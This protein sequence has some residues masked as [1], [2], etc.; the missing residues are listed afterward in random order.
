MKINKLPQGIERVRARAWVVLSAL[1]A[2][3]A[4]RPSGPPPS[5]LLVTIDTL[6]ADRLGA[7]GARNVRTPVLDALAARGVLFEEALASA[8]LTLPS[9]ST[10]LSGLEPPRHG[11]R[12]NGTY[13]FPESRDTLATRL[14]ARGHATAAFV[15]AYVLDRR[16][17]LQRGFAAYDDRIERRLEGTSVL[18]SERPGSEVV[19]AAQRWLS[20]AKTPFFA[21]V[22]LYDPHAPY[23]PPSPFLEEYAGRPY[24]GEVAYTDACLGRLFSAAESAAKGRLVVVVTGDHG[25]SLGEHGEATHGFFVY[26]PTLRVPLVLAGP[27]V[28]RGERRPGSARTADIAP[29]VL[30][31]VGLDFPAGLDGRNL[32]AGPLSRESYA[33]AFY[34]AS[35]GWAPLFSYRLG[36]LKLVDAPRPEIYDLAADPAETTSL[37]DRRP[38]DLARLRNALA[39]FRGGDS[40]GAARALEPEVEER[41]RALGYSGAAAPA[42][43]PGA[44]L[45]D[46]KDA[47]PS[48]REFEEATWAEGR[49]DLAAA[50]AGYRRLLAREPDNPVFRRS[51]AGAL[52]RAGRKDEA[53]RVASGPGRDA[54]LLH[55][56]ALALAEAG[57]T[58]EAIRSEAHA[59][60]LNPTLPEPHNHL[61]V[62]EAQRGR[63]REALQALAE[64][65]RLDPNNPQAWN[66]QGNVLRALGRRDDATAAYRRAAELAP[67]YVDPLN[68]LGVLAVEANDLNAAAQFFGRVLA[69]DPK[70]GEAKLNLAVV[71]AGRG[72]P[73]AARALT[74]ELLRPE[75]PP[76]LVGR[77]RA[78]LRTLPR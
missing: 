78:F 30:A 4:C 12:D 52:R 19:E 42:P 14:A 77:A 32:F 69:I 37:A 71:E 67:R 29:T 73:Q 45:V 3:V 74:E 41:L 23:D 53:T 68:G 66:N 40:P 6:R 16:F 43:L 8:P 39:A 58:E 2:F 46:P 20:Q 36:S 18:E 51:L 13:V 62:L 44:R 63:P 15:G 50:I 34:P 24:D 75:T 76:A 47:L 11:V 27:G 72:R 25:E 49:G 48:F 22:H 57:R 55:E 38:D 70:Y 59:I 17:G 7:Y 61:G 54:V 9:H 21:W 5:V 33:E 65:L 64:A 56:Q 1:V 31:L 35:F 60:A 10:I 28:P 26:Q